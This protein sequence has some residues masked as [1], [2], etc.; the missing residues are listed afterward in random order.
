MLVTHDLVHDLV[1]LEWA[2]RDDAASKR[3]HSMEI[4]DE[5]SECQTPAVWGQDDRSAFENHPLPRIPS[6]ESATV[7]RHAETIDDSPEEVIAR[8]HSERAARM[9]RSSGGRRS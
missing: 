2:A 8:R 4:E 9:D 3:E 5:G 7:E 1:C 6:Y